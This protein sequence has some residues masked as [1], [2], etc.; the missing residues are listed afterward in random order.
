GSSGLQPDAL[1]TMLR[2]EH[3]PFSF[4]NQELYLIHSISSRKYRSKR[5][6]VRQTNGRG[7]ALLRLH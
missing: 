7:K 6:I 1:A 5:S 2:R 3:A 4:R